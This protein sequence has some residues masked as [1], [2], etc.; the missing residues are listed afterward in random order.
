MLPASDGVQDYTTVFKGLC[1]TPLSPAARSHVSVKALAAGAFSL[2]YLICI[3]I[4][5]EFRVWGKRCLYP[6]RRWQKKRTS[7][8]MNSAQ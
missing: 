4:A 8:M 2:I 3:L 5:R 7:W 1:V 6:E